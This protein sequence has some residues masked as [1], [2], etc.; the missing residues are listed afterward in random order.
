MYPMSVNPFTTQRLTQA[1]FGAKGNESLI[2]ENPKEN[3]NDRDY[4]RKAG[5]EPSFFL[6]DRL[7]NGDK[8]RDGI[9]LIRKLLLTKALGTQEIVS[10]LKPNLPTEADLEKLVEER[11]LDLKGEPVTPAAVGLAL[12]ARITADQRAL[13]LLFPPKKGLQDS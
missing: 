12:L 6:P 11:G 7:L 5:I 3:P 8:E 2:K 13:D 1:K 10:L 4:F 9:E